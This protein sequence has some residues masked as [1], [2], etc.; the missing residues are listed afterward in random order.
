MCGERQ[1]PGT[2]KVYGKSFLKKIV[3]WN[4]LLWVLCVYLKRVHL[5]LGR[6]KC[7]YGNEFNIICPSI[8]L[9]N[10][11]IAFS[12]L[13]NAYETCLEFW[14]HLM[15]KIVK[16][17]THLFQYMLSD[18][19]NSPRSTNCSYFV[20]RRAEWY[21]WRKTLTLK[22]SRQVILAQFASS[23]CQFNT[24]LKLSWLLIFDE[25]YYFTTLTNFGV[26][27]FFWRDFS[28]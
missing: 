4:Q 12:I 25:R 20:R 27:L 2:N 10:C 26:D 5:K 8:V 16:L 23:V 9:I 7:L 19:M 28:K 6:A 22:N 13:Q 14:W 21:L 24:V 18:T 11:A 1:Q 17:M 15:E 3:Y